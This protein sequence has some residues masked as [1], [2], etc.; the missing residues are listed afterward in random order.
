MR[1]RISIR[2][3]ARPSV[4]PQVRPSQVFFDGRK[5]RFSGERPSVA[6]SGAEYSALLLLPGQPALLIKSL[7]LYIRYFHVYFCCCY[8]HYNCYCSYFRQHK[9]AKRFLLLLFLFLGPGDVS[10]FEFVKRTQIV[11][12][13]HSFLMLLFL[14]LLFLFSGDV[15]VFDREE[16][17]G[18]RNVTVMF[19][20]G[21]GVQA[22][23]SNG[24]MN[25]YI[26]ASPRFYVN[27]C[28]VYV[29]NQSFVCLI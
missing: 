7:R 14:F 10:V 11:I 17:V 5:S 9:C 16:D 12:S 24:V 2:G 28:R 27:N 21:T 19:P 26:S 6:A 8:Y 3:C 4:C 25:V 23:E 29:F 18:T 1:L 15:S 20:S 22:V 13:W